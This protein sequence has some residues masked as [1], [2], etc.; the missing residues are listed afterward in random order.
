MK[1]GEFSTS[2]KLNTFFNVLSD[3]N[4]EV[5]HISGINNIVA[6]FGSRNIIEDC[7]LDTCKMGHTA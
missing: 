2:S 3:L 4:V 7:T 5:M 1:R 6:D